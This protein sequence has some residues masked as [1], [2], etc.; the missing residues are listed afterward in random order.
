MPEGEKTEKA[1]PKKRNDERKKG[2]VFMSRDAVSVATLI[3]SFS[4]LWLTLPNFSR[5]LGS[6]MTYCLEMSSDSGG[7]LTQ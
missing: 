3:G 2:N 6:F 5:E 4:V 7:D 1:T